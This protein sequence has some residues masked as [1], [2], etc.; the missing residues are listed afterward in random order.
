MVMFQYSICDMHFGIARFNGFLSKFILKNTDI[1]FFFD[2]TE[3]Q[4]RPHNKESFK[5]NC[6]YG[7]AGNCLP[8]SGDRVYRNL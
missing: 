5:Q 8:I 6:I 3:R 2:L 1:M 7:F 4:V